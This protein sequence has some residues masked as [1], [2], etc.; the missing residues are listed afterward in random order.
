MNWSETITVFNRFS[1]AD[2]RI[3]WFPTILYG[4]S[5]SEKSRER[6]S[7]GTRSQEKVV[8]VLIPSW[9]YI[10]QYKPPGSLSG[11]HALDLSIAP[12]YFT[13]T[14]GDIIFRGETDYQLTEAG[15]I[16]FLSLWAEKTFTAKE[17]KDNSNGAPVRKTAHYL[18]RS[19]GYGLQ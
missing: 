2:R 13:L 1:A 8:T 5:W 4:C 12:N 7:G 10:N 15:K 14:P 6:I 17:V 3:F 11:Y 9:R 16:D 18:A 19:E